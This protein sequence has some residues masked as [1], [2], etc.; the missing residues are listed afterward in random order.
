[1]GFFFSW[2]FTCFLLLGVL[3]IWRILGMDHGCNLS[4][5]M[6]SS[7]RIL[8]VKYQGCIFSDFEKLTFKVDY[9]NYIKLKGKCFSVS[10]LSRLFL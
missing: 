5:I 10:F 9:F 6:F 7:A 8:G 3:V 2:C 1:M 4:F